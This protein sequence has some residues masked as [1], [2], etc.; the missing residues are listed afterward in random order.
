MVSKLGL[1][2]ARWQLSTPV[3]F[4]VLFLLGGQGLIEVIA[5]NDR[6]INP[7]FL[8]KYVKNRVIYP[9]P[10]KTPNL[11]ISEM[12][13]L[14]GKERYDVVIPVRDATTILFSKYKNK[15]SNF[16]KMPIPNYEVVMK[17]RDKDCNGKRYTMS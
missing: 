2:I 10:E 12:Y 4:L 5:A 11:F 7:T 15:F 3:I 16:T 14:I 9:S 1:Y 6:K 8:S 13:K 17:G